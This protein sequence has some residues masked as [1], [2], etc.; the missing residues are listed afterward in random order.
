MQKLQFQIYPPFDLCLLSSGSPK[1]KP[2]CLRNL[3]TEE[4]GWDK[5]HS[6]CPGLDFAGTSPYKYS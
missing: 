4:P 1:D 6:P 3:P 2:V 5:A